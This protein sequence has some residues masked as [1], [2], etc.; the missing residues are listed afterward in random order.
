MLKYSIHSLSG[1]DRKELLRSLEGKVEDPKELLP[2]KIPLFRF[3]FNKRESVIVK[4]KQDILLVELNDYVIPSLKIA[5][6]VSLTVPVIT[7]DLGAIK[8]VTNGAD[9]MRPGIT[10]IG[11]DVLEG[12]LVVVVEERKKT[13]LCFG[14]AQ[15]DAVDMREK[16]GGKCV[17]NLHYLKDK[18]WTFE[19][20]T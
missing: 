18:Y 9:I 1:K 14:V 20:E 16:T 12:N 17:K 11:D 3:S 13:P 4:N 2:K 7:V 15:Y 8:F 10:E 5:R 6:Q 19:A